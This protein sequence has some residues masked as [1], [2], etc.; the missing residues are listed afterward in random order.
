MVHPDNQLVAQA[1]ENPAVYKEIVE[2]YE[3]KLLAYVRRIS[4][5]NIEDAEDVLQEVFVKAYYNLNAFNDK[6]K[7]S[8]WIYRIAHN[9]TMSELRKRHVRP[10]YYYIEEDL[11]RLSDGLEITNDLEKKEFNA[12]VRSILE[13]MDKKYGEILILKF[14]E[15]KDYKEISDILK[16]PAGT[17]ATRINR[18]KKKFREVYMKLETR[19]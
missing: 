10:L 15:E 9:T 16:I 1:R 12:H 5:L 3:G 2:R 18:A 8:S 4:G 17:V 11:I 13:G 19:N 14:L 6:L 7:F